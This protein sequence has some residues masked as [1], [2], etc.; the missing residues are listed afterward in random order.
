M[1]HFYFKSL[2]LSLLMI[3]VGI[4]VASAAP[5]DEIKSPDDVV[6]GK[7]YY[8][9]GVYTASGTE[10]A[11][12][13]APTDAKG[14]FTGNAVTD[15][16]AA[17]PIKFTQVDGG[18]TLTTPN[19]Y[20]VRPHTSNGQT[21]LVEDE[22]VL[23]L[24]SGKTKEG[25]GKGIKIGPYSD[26][27]I[28]CN[29]Q[30]PKIG[31]YKGTQW[32]VTLIECGDAVSSA[33]TFANTAP[34]IEFPATNTYSQEVTTAE[35]Y[36]GTVTYEITA[37]TAGAT[38]D[39]S[40][41]TVTQA[42]SVTV[43]A[44]APAV[45]GF[46]SSTATYTLTV[47]DAR[48]ENGLAFAES[49]QEVT[50]G[51]VLNAP[52]LT[53]PNNLA[54]TYSS[55]DTSVAT[56]DADGN[57]TGVAVG[58]ATITASFE[59]NNQYMAGS[60]SYTINVK[61][62]LPE[63]ALFYESVS[64]YN[65]SSDNS[66]VLS[67]TYS[68]LDSDNWDSF[69]KV[70][71]GKVVGG[72]TDGHL[73][74]GSSS[75]AG[76]AVTGPIALTGNGK[77]TY[78]VMRYDSSNAGK[79][80]I[81]ADGADVAGDTEVTGTEAWVEKTVYLTNATGNVVITFASDA[82]N[83]RIRVDDILLV[84]AE[85]VE[86]SSAAT[87][88]ETEP[89]ID[90]PE[91]TTYSQEAT[92]AEGYT[93]TVTYE[94]TA[95][96][97][98]AT[99]DGSTVTVTKA[100][101]VT[102]KATAPAVEGFLS[103]TATYTLT[104]TDAREENGLAFAES[105]QEVTVGEVLNA[106]TL[107]NPNNL[108]VTYSSSD[109]S[110]ATVDADG[111][112]TGVAVGTA[113]ITASFEGN[114][115]YMAGSASYT[116]RVKKATVLPEGTLFYESVS[117]YTGTSDSSA[118]LTPEYSGLDYDNWAYFTK[119]YPGG[120]TEG[121][122]DGHLKF[123]TGS[124]VGKAMT[125]SIALRGSGKLTYKVKRYSTSDAGRLTI[126]VTGADIV[127][128]SDVDVTGTDA[129]VEKTVNLT[130]A[131]G[132]VVITFATTDGGKRIR[133]DDILLV[134][135]EETPT[136]YTLVAT[137][138]EGTETE[139]PF[140]G[141]TLTQEFPGW[142]YFYIKA[143]DG[144]LY[145]SE[146]GDHYVI[147]ADNHEN[148][149][150]KSYSS[151]DV[152]ANRFFFRRANSW[153]FT[154]TEATDGIKLTVNPESP[155]G[156]Y[157]KMAANYSPSEPFQ[158][159]DV[160]FDEEG[161]LTKEM[162][163]DP[164]YIVKT[165]DYDAYPLGASESN[166]EDQNIWE[167]SGENNTVGFLEGEYA[168]KY[169]VSEAGT[170][171]FTLDL[172][173]KTIT[174]LPSVRKYTLVTAGGDE[175]AFDSELKITGQELPASTEFYIKDNYGKVYYAEHG[176]NIISAENH[177]N[178][179]TYYP[180]EDDTPADNPEK[181]YFMKANTWNFTITE[182]TDEGET[183]KL[184]VTP[185]TEG[186]T[187]YMLS[188]TYLTASEDVFDENLKLT[189]E[190]EAG[191]AFYIERSDDYG[192]TNMSA[193]E[194]NATDGSRNW[195]FSETANQ[196]GFVMGEIT[197]VYRMA[198][199]GTYTF[200]LDLENKTVSVEKVPTTYTLVAN[201]EG[202]ETE[203]PFTELTLTQEL[204]KGTKFYIK[205]SKDNIYYGE[206][207][208]SVIYAENHENLNTAYPVE[209]ATVTEKPEKFELYKDATWQFTITEPTEAGGTIKLTVIP[210]TIEE[211]TKYMLSSTYLETSE[212]VFDENLKITKKFTA[213]ESFYITREDGFG[214]FNMT[215]AD[216]NDPDG[217]YVWEFSED[218]PTV[219]YLPAK[220]INAFR[221]KNA[222]TYTITLD[223]E[224]QTVTVEAVP[225]TYTLMAN[226]GYQWDEYEFTGLEL[227]QELRKGTEFYIK[228]NKG[229]IYYGEYLNDDICAENHENLSTYYPI[230]DA[231]VTAKP[232]PFEL[233]K[234]ATWH[235]TITEPTEAGE[236]IKLTVIPSTI[237][238]ETKYML[239]S[240]YLVTS[241][242]VFDENLQI[243][244]EFTAG[245]PFYITRE[246][247]FGIFNM[248]A[249]DKND[250][251]GYYVWDFSEDAPTVGYIPAKIINAFRM[252]NAGTYTIT[253]DTENLTV[254][255][256]AV[257][258][259]YTLVAVGETPTEYPFSG[260]TLTQELPASTEFYIKDN[261]GNEYRGG[262]TTSERVFITAENHE[263]LPTYDSGKNFYLIKAN[264]WVF[265]ITEPTDEGATIKLT[266]NP[267]T[268][269]ETKYMIS[270]SL[271]EE[272]EDV[273]DENLQLTKEMDTTPF[274]II[275]SDD[276]AIFELTAKDRNHPDGYARFV[277]SEENNSAEFILG[278]RR[279]MY[280]MSKAG[281][282][283]FTLDLENSTVSVE[284][285][286]EYVDL[287]ISSAEWATFVTPSA[288]MFPDD[289]EAYIITEVENGNA[290]SEQ[291]VV[292]PANT[293]VI[294]HGTAGVHKLP[295]ADDDVYLEFTNMLQASDGT[296]TGDGTIYVLAVQDGQAGFAR[297]ANGKKL[298]EGKAYL[299]VD[300]AGAKI[301]LIIDGESTGIRDIENAVDF[302]DGDWYNLQGVKV[303]SPQRGIYI[304]NGKKV[305]IK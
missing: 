119:V 4:N 144:N 214:I 273:F 172:E 258:T 81:S 18:W 285:A 46:L 13:Y 237:D 37:N 270:S 211:E 7:S 140:S 236:T 5:G 278:E 216:K 261:F 40:T 302:S 147:T 255:V 181:F 80:T 20:Y 16:S 290:K 178:M 85:T 297:L 125:G 128:N 210:S 21:Y 25:E 289:V 52:T 198:E 124:Y 121:A 141:L 23:Q 110:V 55:S 99:I 109:T 221:M 35:G 118:E 169:R 9:K 74:F 48:E 233:F 269:G 177:E 252:K 225:T 139:Y 65:G 215:A 84:E 60:A 92:T 93:G 212:D 223:T 243:T 267:Q 168:F 284:K 235:F 180:V 166:V 277:F 232:G 234:T 207:N 197:N 69:D 89:S 158:D 138:N 90:F 129:W 56:V 29:M 122:D 149:N 95:N 304:H 41:V 54:V 230:E 183:I 249:A 182:P 132:D 117:G 97:A 208:K 157:Y 67:T 265:T 145:G 6:S 281:T 240:S 91:T 164:F 49:S 3:V 28:Q 251:D 189:K 218:A 116:V 42:G 305:I 111:N 68:G 137:D 115:Q 61:K 253:L 159:P 104:V 45:E 176:K 39:G 291:I 127:E 196:V 192:I 51:E 219:G 114:N 174:A 31:A 123:G 160:V 191:T 34:S 295:K 247:G 30:S 282:Y 266:V 108:A 102:V 50:V 296:V 79:L 66:T 105:S 152:G 187:K 203:Y 242:D 153:V 204:S 201:I 254:T 294:V 96:T 279:N 136:T 162:T 131:N 257:P 38:I 76:T 88:A 82:S 71:A 87:F 259:T 286:I 12:Y 59:G 271:N 126:S 241:E 205:D 303:T 156:T 165:D 283:T 179:D 226:E 227:S 263:N 70:Y 24:A 77:L 299:Q 262:E 288:V 202:T 175:V 250:P 224:N 142:T 1:K 151:D 58:T 72:A 248:S 238:E 154:I 256:E 293:P 86:V 94:I 36:T 185:Q 33:A 280:E 133:V 143:S 83:K 287:T 206:Y 194:A 246:D 184:T 150:A 231:T 274:Y 101:S 98:G 292:A 26:Y 64:G 106:P 170:Y 63:G 57:V 53:N 186:E 11:C 135:N 120:V 229:N 260:L 167:F 134:Q 112:V 300:N 195:D 32:D 107:T 239:T 298:S 148:L 75:A 103:S 27:Y 22:V 275:R 43:K 62:A 8:I 15:I 163:T 213:G 161:K 173:N 2:F 10:T 19:G 264:T 188:A 17:L 44:T 220:M 199:A 244:K 217:Y 171:N 73:K 272:S 193:A 268:E 301:N 130:G 200:T 209:D 47:T 14:K 146:D 245:Q 190:M 155:E 78:K 228:D 222:D 276:Y 100:G 113:T